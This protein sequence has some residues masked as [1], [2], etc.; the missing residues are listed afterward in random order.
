M[1]Y[2]PSIISVS[3]DNA[4]HPILVGHQRAVR[5]ITTSEGMKSPCEVLWVGSAPPP[6]AN[7]DPD[8]L[9][10]VWRLRDGATIDFAD[11]QH[12]TIANARIE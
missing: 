3:Y 9:R 10:D 7:P 4:A 12:F 6:N 8:G 1:Y 11:G 2:V 5:T